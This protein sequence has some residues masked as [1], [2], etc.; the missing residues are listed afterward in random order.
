[1][2]SAG[3][4]I[5]IAFILLISSTLILSPILSSPMFYNA[6]DP[7]VPPAIVNPANQ[8]S[9]SFPLLPNVS[10]A[11]VNTANQPSAVSF[12]LFP[13]VVYAQ[14]D[15]SGDQPSSSSSSSSFS[16]FPNVAYAQ[17]AEPENQPSASFPLTVTVS[18]SCPGLAPVPAG[19]SGDDTI[20]GTDNA[21]TGPTAIN[22]LG[23]NDQLFGCGGGDTING[24]NNNDLLDG[25]DG[26][27][28]L[29]G[30]NGDDTVNGGN[31]NDIV[32]GGNGKDTLN[33]GAGDDT[34]IGGN[35]G[36]LLTG[37]SG[38]DKFF[39]GNAKDTVVDFT[40]AEGDTL[41][42]C[43]NAIIKTVL[44]N[45][46]TITDCENDFTVTGT[47][48]PQAET[49]NLYKKDGQNLVLI[50]TTN[51]I[52]DTDGEW[53]ITLSPTDPNL[54]DGTFTLV[55]IPV[56]DGQESEESISNEVTLIINCPLT[57]PVINDPGTITD[58]TQ[59]FDVTGTADPGTTI[60]LYKKDG[61]T[62][63][64]LDG[65]TITDQNGA[66]SITLNPTDINL[67]Q[68]TFTLV[69]TASNQGE[70]DVTSAEVTLI[71]LCPPTI[72]AHDDVTDC[73]TPITI[74]GTA[75]PGTDSIN[76]YADGVQISGLNIVPDAQGVWS[77]DLT[78]PTD[79]NVGQHTFTATS[80]E[81]GVESEL[82]NEVTF[83]ISCAPTI[84]AHD[85]VTDCTTPITISGTAA[86]G[87]DSINLYADGVQISGLNIV[88]DAQGVWSVDL[89][90]PTDINVGQHTFTATSVEN[91]VESELSNEV[92]FTI[93]CAP[94]ID[95]HDDVTDCTTPIT[96]SGTAAPGTD[97]I[98]LYADG[99]QIS[100][101]NIVPDAQGVWSVDLTAPTDINVGQ[102]TFTAT[103]V[104][105][106]VESELSNEVTFTISCAPTID[107][108]D[109]VTDCTTPITISG[110]AAPGTD[111]INLYADGVQI[112]GL[113]IVPDAQGVWSVD[114][115][116]PTDINVGQHTFTATSVENGV[117][118]ELSNEVTFTI[119]C[120]PT[121]DA[122]D[123]VTDCTTPI[124]IS[125]TA[126]PGTDSINLYADGVQISGLNIV[127]D[128][129]GVWSVDLTAPTDINVGQHTFTATSVEN[130]VES[131]LSNEVTFTISCAPTIDAHDDVT[132]CT[133]P[134]TISGTAAPGTDSINL[135][136][137]GVQ[138]SGLNI[139]PDAQG[140]W[141]VDL[142][143]PTD[144]NVGQHTFTATSVENGVESEL[145]NE[146]TFTISCAP[147]IDAHD[148]VTDCTTPITISGTAAPGTDSINLYAD[149]VQ[150]SGLNIVPDA[151]GVWSVDLTAPTDINVGQHTFTATSVENGVESE[152]SNEVTFTIS[153]AP[154]IDAHDDV[155]DCTTPITISGTAA[156]GTD[157]INLYADGVQI[158]GL[159]IVPDA[160]GV[161]SVDL[162]APTDI[163]V[164]QHTFTATSV[165]NGVES[166]LSNEVT[167]TIS[168]APTID[169][170]DDVTDCT[171]PITI[172]GTAAP[173]TDSINLYAD[174]VQIS[175][176]NI[177]PDAQGVWSVDLTAPTDINVGQ[178][179]FT[180]TSVENGVESELSNE[181]TFTI[182]CAPTID[183]HDD[184]T[185]C[186][187]P[188]TISGTAAPGT[189]S[190]N[191]YADGVQIS[192]LNIVP[193]AQGVWS[194]DLT[195]PTDINVGQHTFTATS[196]ENG[197]ESEL[198]NEV[199]FTISCAPT[200]DAHDDVT[201]CTTPITISG[202][203]APG[204][205][206]IN[207]YADGV[208][209]SGLNIVPDAQGVWS[210]DLTAPTDI[211]VGQHTFTAT[212]VENGVESEL[213]NEVTFTIS[214]APTIDAHDDVTD[215]TTPITISGTAAPGTD[216]INLYADG[217][218]IS[219]L[220]IVPD[221]QGVWSVDLTAPTDINVGQ[222]TFTATSVENGV[223]SELSNEV[224]FTISCAPTITQP[225]LVP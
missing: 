139:V 9:T 117:E 201:D 195:A 140:V 18:T 204:T 185:D 72:D 210:V 75:A 43:D 192:G 125:G 4:I 85:D 178:H 162:T 27:D 96:I 41:D 100:G 116:A 30:G 184:V 23:G 172:S 150:I 159:N 42:Q 29:N 207:L 190:I 35:G 14:S 5:S 53:S 214:C 222:H 103:S 208:Q 61:Q 56:L 54:G 64:Q 123:D 218:Q 47:A 74:S 109:D 177:V 127:P 15:N 20:Y 200:I 83:T 49:I 158:S 155:T 79:I 188:I 94:T 3:S 134:I 91:G 88:P 147:T 205:D 13:N 82:S 114:L 81:N 12:S 71:I 122:H 76:L 144:I 167:F 199:T 145:S 194:V 220:N 124:T 36:E 186:T 84:D 58:C 7:N 66:W 37:G 50:G 106:G 31:G 133:T 60:T 48:H 93:S 175:G 187:T 19:T 130:G 225:L 189:D 112:S 170:H 111:S 68:G 132:D 104:E 216:S 135:Y 113:N 73:T 128:A 6:K 120:A 224:T 46:G 16:L 156:P 146:V 108:H 65:T 22:G 8:P 212:S 221:A 198:S 26:N 152:L 217:V 11:I 153:C 211:N 24:G 196:V 87:T 183:A 2:S 206:S 193:D 168:C 86:P 181:V 55:A 148:D 1:M 32:D 59:T 99:V 173:G 52:D 157:S 110:T 163:N 119:S 51:D 136:A 25:G 57:Q 165:E 102:H 209:I 131:E 95:A 39:C 213:S 105:N 67:G 101:L 62:T 90:A 118:S 115:T 203:A 182:S 129:Q 197:V 89:T 219:G 174:G 80:V 179:T 45:P 176:L 126:A 169:A 180:A 17:T 21:E 137:D 40:P 151:Q 223:E 78:A 98:N 143:A 10:P 63:T 28:N 34:I 202:T 77:V 164:G 215:C 166:E 70:T 33:G 149:G 191:L 142:T 161:W 107:A 141:S 44:N 69:A 121:I 97:S 92:T 160:Q 138:I 38:A 171:T 154:T